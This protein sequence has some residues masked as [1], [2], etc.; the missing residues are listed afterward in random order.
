MVK[1]FERL[2][3]MSPTGALRVRL[4]DDGDVIVAVSCGDDHASV[5][6]CCRASGGQSPRT[7]KALIDL[8][9]AMAADNEDRACDPRKGL[10]G[11]GI[12]IQSH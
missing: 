5:E 1:T 6:F 4:A 8:A 3:D 7:H 9:A 2:E 10:R 12:D 11:V